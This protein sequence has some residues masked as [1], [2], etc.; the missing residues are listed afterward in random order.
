MEKENIKCINCK[1]EHKLENTG[2]YNSGNYNSGNRNLGNRNSGD[3]NSGD[4]NS[5][6]FNTDE[7]KVRFFNKDSD[8]TFSE[9]FKGN[10]VYPD[11]Q[12][13]Y[14]VSYADLPKDEQTTDTKAIDGKLKTRTYKEAWVEYWERASEDDKKWFQSLPNFS[15]E[16]FAELTGVQVGQKSLKGTK[17]KVE[18][19]GVSYEAIIQ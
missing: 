18:V 2:C 8:I 4:R 11:L 15:A 5:G 16:L 3:Y 17:V 9:F 1:E 12:T 6:W 14:W 10:I 7:P 19:N 13:C